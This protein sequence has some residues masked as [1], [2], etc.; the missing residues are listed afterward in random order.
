MS[1]PYARIWAGPRGWCR[2]PRCRATAVLCALVHEGDDES[3]QTVREITAYGVAPQ[4]GSA[5]TDGVAGIG[6]GS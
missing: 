6:W 5:T 3:D 4:N 1:P 2:V